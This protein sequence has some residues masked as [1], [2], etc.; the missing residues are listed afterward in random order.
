[1][2][3]VSDRPLLQTL[4]HSVEGERGAGLISIHPTHPAYSQ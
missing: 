4:G 3:G 1:M 2:A